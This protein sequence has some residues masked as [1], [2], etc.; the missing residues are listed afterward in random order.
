VTRSIDLA[1]YD[2]L[3]GL[4]LCGSGLVEGVYG[5]EKLAEDVG[6][7]ERDGAA[8][9]VTWEVEARLYRGRTDRTYVSVMPVAL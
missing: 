5:N 2:E 4:T 7:C 8:L 3:C 9:N 1:E 6:V